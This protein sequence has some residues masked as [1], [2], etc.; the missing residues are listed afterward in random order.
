MK[1]YVRSLAPLGCLIVLLVAP[2][3]LAQQLAAPTK[4]HEELASEVGVWDAD[5]SLWESADAEPFKSKGVETNKMLGKLWL[6]SDFESDFGGLK[7]AGHGQSGWDP[8]KKKYVGT[9]IDTMSPFVQT[10]EG[11]Y[12]EDSHT[13][14]M[15]STGIDPQTGKEAKSKMITRYTSDDEKTFELHMPVEG[16]D[17]KWWKMMEIKYTRR[18]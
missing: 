9:W 2:A 6:I 1:R 3:A 18:K 16:E 11:D 10:M 13:L 4:Q 14:T 15:I 8:L 7:F 12:D 17:G 5:M